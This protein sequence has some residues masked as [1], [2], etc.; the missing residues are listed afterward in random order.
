[1]RGSEHDFHPHPPPPGDYTKHP[2]A[3]VFKEDEED[4]AQ[5]WAPNHQALQSGGGDLV[6]QNQSAWHPLLDG[7]STNPL[8]VV[9]QSWLAGEND[10]QSTH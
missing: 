5:S 1:M 4:R 2:P 10:I 6:P 8:H 9:I 7:S 3:S